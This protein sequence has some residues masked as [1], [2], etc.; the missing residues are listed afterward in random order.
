MIYNNVVL[1]VN[2]ENDIEEVRSLLSEQ[3]Q[4]SSEEPVCVRFGVY[5]SQADEQQFLLIGQWKTQEDLDRHKEA[6]AFTELFIPK[7]IPL[8]SLVPHPS[9]LVR[10]LS[11]ND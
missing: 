1:T 9:D 2:N 10:P 6:K 5:H 11:Q 3:A 4:R 8:V 7:V